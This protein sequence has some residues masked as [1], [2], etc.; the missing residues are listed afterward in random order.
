M[1]VEEL[2]GP[3]TVDTMPPA[4]ITA[5]NDH[6]NVVRTVDQNVR[7]AQRVMEQLADVGIDFNDV[8]NRLL[9]DGLAS[10]QKSFDSLI[11][12]LE[13]KTKTLGR[14]IGAAR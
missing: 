5:F 4:T 6:G 13:R 10:F 12:G 7:E 11:A 8:T 14:P 9:V 3:D 1:Y 2:I